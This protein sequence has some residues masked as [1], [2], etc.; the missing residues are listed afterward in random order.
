M[1][2]VILAGGAGD[3]LW[4][5]SRKNYPKQFL[6]FG[7]R[8]SLF[9]ETIT[10]NI[11]FCKEFVILTNQAYVTIVQGQLQ[12]FQGLSY[13]I[14][15]EEEGR[16]TAASLM[17]LCGILSDSE[18]IFVT[19]SDLSIDSDGYS[20]AIYEAKELSEAGGI[21]LFGVRPE[22]PRTTVGY[23]RYHGAE[24]SRFIEKP[25]EEVAEKLYYEDNVLWN[26]GL[27]LC[28]VATLRQELCRY[29][30][31]PMELVEAGVKNL[32]ESD[33]H[34]MILPGS[35][36]SELP[37]GGIDRLLF[38]QSDALRVVRLRGKWH[39]VSDLEALRNRTESTEDMVIQHHSDNVDVLNEDP[40]RLVVTNG[41]QNAY[42][43]NTTDAVYITDKEHMT[44]IKDILREHGEDYAEFFEQ[45]PMVYRPW[46]TRELVRQGGDYR[47]RKITMYPGG[48]MSFHAHECRT[49]SYTVVSGTLSVQLE[50]HF[51]E[52]SVGEHV[53]IAPEQRHRLFNNGDCDA[54][55]I[56]VDTGSEIAEQDMLHSAEPLTTEETLPDVFRLEPAFKD[57]L[58]GGNR[59]VSLFHKN[60]P[61]D[62]TAESWE[63]SA[64][65][66]GQ[67]IIADGPFAGMKFGEFAHRYGSAACGWKSET[68]DRFPVLIK[69]IDAKGALSI[70]IHP[71]DDY[72]FVNE[73]E[74]GKNEVWYVMD[75]EPG[76][77]LYCGLSRDV[78]KEELE[79]RIAD[80]TLTDVLNRVDVHTGD[81]VFVPAGTIHAIGA[82]ILICEIQQN[83]NSTYRMFDYGRRDKNGNLR[84]L[85]VG[86]AL[87][88]VN[89]KA[90]TVNTKGY[91][92][93][94]EHDGYTQQL[95]VQCKYFQC[96]RYRVETE[97]SIPVDD[98]SFKSI[99][100]LSGEGQ[101]RLQDTTYDMH[102]GDS[103]FVTAGRKLIH[104]YGPCEIIVTNV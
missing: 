91:Q 8:Q 1:K 32:E 35:L 76:A 50:E 61:Y 65:P 21:V 93:P 80:N 101:L 100:V 24:V 12:T 44:D 25:T 67:S 48:T 30:K 42:V 96:N 84:E 6:T 47:I 94:V 83:S 14:V 74:F 7:S 77:F 39:D 57:Y 26:S 78:D 60:S 49:E 5:L 40:S 33:G 54:V 70:Q 104:V 79:R 23:L 72:A 69:F 28:K 59:L 15:V 29:L 53:S 103:F 38:E 2:C 62:I 17:A 19:S 11:P 95:I 52:V 3:R 92:E 90:F 4:P 41:I 9:Q 68:F 34:Q 46:G 37:A 51:Y 89:T 86:K 75:A 18:E 27:F 98:A 99:I 10:R 36:L 43:V 31:K 16:G 58:C 13:R 85:H 56:E 88:V 64:H 45:S 63:L 81:V 73:G 55:L 102:P 20:D 87:D 22:S 71:D 97:A 82:G 66:D